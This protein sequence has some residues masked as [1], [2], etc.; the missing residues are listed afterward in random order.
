MI[1][2]GIVA[3]YMTAICAITKESSRGEQIQV[4]TLTLL[5][6]LTE[7]I[8]HQKDPNVWSLSSNAHGTLS[9]EGFFSPSST[10]YAL[11]MIYAF[12]L[13]CLHNGGTIERILVWRVEGNDDEYPVGHELFSFHQDE[14]RD[15]N[16]ERNQAQIQQ[17]NTKR[18]RGLLKYFERSC[19]LQVVRKLLPKCLSML[20]IHCLRVRRN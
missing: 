7:R 3:L 13:S 12:V 2:F 4:Y 6:L 18:R 11:M 10:M 14:G 20:H 17:S 8:F 19:Q 9:L 15:E 1:L 16:D 5:M